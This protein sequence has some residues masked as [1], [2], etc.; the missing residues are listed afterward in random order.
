MKLTALGILFFI[1]VIILFCLLRYP[2]GTRLPA[3]TSSFSHVPAI[4]QP[5]PVPDKPFTFVIAGDTMFGRMVDYTFKGQNLVKVFDQLDN[6]IFDGADLALLNLEGPI[7]PTKTTPDINPN[8]LVFNFPPETVNVLTWLGINTVSLA[9]NHSQNQ[10]QKGLNNTRQVLK[11]ANIK[12]IGQQNTFT[13]S[14]IAHFDN[15]FQKLSV[16]AINTLENKDDITKTIK[17]EKQAGFF[18]L[19]FPHWGN[20]Y[21]PKHSGAQSTLAHAWIDAGADLIIG[22]HP[23]VVQDTELYR[24]KPIIHSL[25]N[26]VFDQTFSQK[27][28]EGLIVAGQFDDENL[29]LNLLPI[30]S[31]KLQ[32]RFITGDNKTEQLKK[33]YNGLRSDITEDTLEFPR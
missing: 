29:K 21:Q 24:S 2:Y 15:G 16:I 33:L 26:F 13:D 4:P 27:T 7:S 3:P 9:N 10:G 23:H 8:N 20:E 6:S 32:P 18:V 1:A 31:Q 22:S 19:I 30:E 28:Q 17:Q 5:S 11:D 12:T 14:S 25:G